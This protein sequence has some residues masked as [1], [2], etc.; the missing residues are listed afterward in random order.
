MSKG[1][2]LVI[3]DNQWNAQLITDILEHEGFTV[4]EKLDGRSGLEVAM[5]QKPDVI[6]LD[7]MLP[8]MSGLDVMRQ[9][10][11]SADTAQIPI[12]VITANTTIELRAA[13]RQAGAEEFIAKPFTRDFLVH[14]VSRYCSP[15]D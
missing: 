14:L 9:L 1:L 8:D 15:K 5:L 2:I 6:L 10:K 4:I 7:M 11:A 3:E 12:I 13:C